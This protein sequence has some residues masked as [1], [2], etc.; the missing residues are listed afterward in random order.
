MAKNQHNAGLHYRPLNQLGLSNFND[1]IENPI[2]SRFKFNI[3]FSIFYTTGK[4]GTAI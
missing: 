3:P 1:H 4:G 2:D